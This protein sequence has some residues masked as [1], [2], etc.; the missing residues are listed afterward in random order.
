M[1]RHPNL[2]LCQAESIS[3]ARNKGFNKENV[4]GFFD[5]LEKLVDEES[6]DALRIFNVDESGF[7][8]VQEKSSSVIALRGK[9]QVG[10]I[11]SGERGVNTTAVC[12]TRVSG[13]F[14]PPMI[15]FKRKRMHPA[16]GTGSPW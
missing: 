14:I 11:Y 15:I 8:T 13:I 10:F 12:C 4:Y 9:H 16:L 6:I 7:C 1:R 3:I 2:K 5:L